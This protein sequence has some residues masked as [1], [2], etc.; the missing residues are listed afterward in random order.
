MVTSG[1]VENCFGE[2]HFFL[3]LI[4]FLLKLHKIVFQNKLFQFSLPLLC[5]EIT[6][7]FLD[8]CTENA[9]TTELCL[10]VAQTVDENYIEKKNIYIY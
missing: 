3:I 5:I 2:L 9:V 8:Q 1:N 10:F 7:T 4:L 6:F